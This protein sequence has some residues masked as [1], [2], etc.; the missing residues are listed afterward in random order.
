MLGVHRLYAHRLSRPLMEQKD[1]YNTARTPQAIRDWQLDQFN[2]LWQS[3]RHHVPYFHRLQ[4]RHKL[5][6]Q[7]STWQQFK[8]TM[9]IM[10]RKTIQ[11]EREALTSITG[12]PHDWRTTG[13][14]TA[15][16]LKIPVWKSEPRLAGSD[17]WY[18]RSWFGV[19][20]ADKLFLIWG[21][22]HL[23]GRGLQGWINRTQRHLK[24]TLLGYYRWPAYNLREQCLREAADAILTFRPTYLI[25][26]AVA[27]DRFARVNRHRWKAFHHLGLKVAIASG[28][29]FPNSDSKKLITEV[30]GCPVA[31]EY[32]AVETGPIAHQRPDGRYTVFWR[33]YFLEGYVSEHLPS[34]YEILVTSLFPRC[35]PLVR[36]KLGDLITTNPD[37]DHFRQEFE[38]VIG[39]SKDLIILPHGAVV[40]SEAFTHAVK[41]TSSMTGYQVAQSG[42]GD[43][44]LSYVAENPLASGDIVEI[45]RRLAHIHTD[46]AAIRIERVETLTPTMSGK[47]RRVIRT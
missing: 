5:P 45:R 14:S 43:V 30:L 24:D 29:S 16:P 15:E 27:L 9:P 39:R 18:G 13:G 38:A 17:L 44:T 31:M 6:S 42:D 47:T 11:H 40:H 26:Y 35:V 33:H 12:E 28:E 7:F 37:E 19:T 34:A 2:R 3:I 25:A 22:S 23:L 32:G 21:Q 20:P 36:Y 4:Q 1:F 41:E 46:L 8:A 10:E